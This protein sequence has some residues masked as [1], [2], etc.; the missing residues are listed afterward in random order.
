MTIPQRMAEGTVATGV[1]STRSVWEGVQRR[2]QAVPLAARAWD[3][4]LGAREYALL[5]I[6]LGVLLM[7]LPLANVVSLLVAAA[8]VYAIGESSWSHPRRLTLVALVLC[9]VLYAKFTIEQ[10]RTGWA[11]HSIEAFFILRSLD[12]IRSP[13]PDARGLSAADRL[14]RF[15]L[16]IFFLPTLSLGPMTSYGDFYRSYQPAILNRR[17]LL[18]PLLTKIGWGALK[19]FVLN[20][21]ALFL[22]HNL[23][24]EQTSQAAGGSLTLLAHFDPRL[25]VWSV[26][27]LDLI[28][29]YLLFSGCI[30][31]M[32]GLSRLLGFHLPENFDKPLFSTSLVRY[33]KASNISVYRWLMIHVFFRYWDHHCTTAKVVTTFLASAIWHLA[34]LRT[35]SGE[36]VL[37]IGLAFASFSLAVAALMRLTRIRG[38]A[39]LTYRG[40]TPWVQGCI[41]AVKLVCTF[42]MVALIHQLFWNGLQGRPLAMTIE[43]YGRLLMRP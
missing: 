4:T 9:G 20:R 38:L 27:C 21:A 10:P 25:L 16:W 30:D 41:G 34:F 17:Q 40:H 15:I 33:W 26:V 36:G 1:T 23:L 37:Q 19:L 8:L 7:W 29:F 12:F 13:H 5:L 3:G 32:L 11:R 2:F 43:V 35:L 24:L 28:R 22:Q 6:S 42:S 31:I 39:R 18:F 14:G